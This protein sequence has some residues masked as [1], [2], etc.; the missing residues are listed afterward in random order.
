[1]NLT[2]EQRKLL[3]Q[4]VAVY[5]DGCASEFILTRTMAG[6]TLIYPGHDSITT[7]A[8]DSDFDQLAHERLIH[9]R[10][11]DHNMVVGKPTQLGIE[12]VASGNLDRAVSTTM[13]RTINSER[14]RVSIGHGGSPVWKDLRDFLERRLGLLTDEFNREPTAGLTTKE[15]LERML[16]DASFAFLLM[17]G[18][19]STPDG[20]VRARENVVHEIGLFQGRLGFQ[21]AIVL[22]EEG[23][24]E[25]SNIHGLTQIRFPKGKILAVSEE[26]R[27]VLEREQ[28]FAAGKI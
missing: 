16:A 26:L 17:T 7:D 4:L 18:E 5:N 22:L 3:Q 1:L 8:S 9:T 21:R 15:V 13:A 11:N 10:R 27:A 20:K 24:A 14:G 23:C 19:D 6:A 25:F 2:I 28:I 12:I